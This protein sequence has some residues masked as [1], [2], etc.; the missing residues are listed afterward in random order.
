MSRH[1]APG[2]GRIETCRA[3]FGC[4][5]DLQWRCHGAKKVAAPAADHGQ[6]RAA[7]VVALSEGEN[8]RT[9]AADDGLSLPWLGRPLSPDIDLRSTKITEV[10]MMMPNMAMHA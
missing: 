3:G 7:A 6:H 1:S 4:A 2:A 8:T 10:A 9:V 5:R